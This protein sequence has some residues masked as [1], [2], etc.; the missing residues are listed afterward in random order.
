MLAELSKPALLFWWHS[1]SRDDW[2][3]QGLGSRS[4]WVGEKRERER[5]GDFQRGN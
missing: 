3:M 2:G 1:L 5:I 4:G